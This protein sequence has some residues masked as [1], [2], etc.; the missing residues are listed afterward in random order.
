MPIRTLETWTH[1]A[2]MLDAQHTR[3]ALWAPDAFYVS[4]ELVDG[5]SLPMLPQPDGWFVIK[6]RCPAGT[7]YRFSIDGE[8]NVPDPASR[9][10][11][12]GPD[13]ASMVVDP[14][15]YHWQ[16]SAWQGRPWHQAV[17]YELHVGLLGGFGAVR[18]HLPRLVELGITAI[19]LMPLA[20]FPGERNWGYDGV[21]PYAPQSSYG[22]PDELKQLIDAA[23]GLGLAVILDVVYNHFG[24]DGSY[25]HQYAS[26][27]FR[28]DHQTPWGAAIDFRRR[29]VRD[30]FIDNALMWLLE[31]RFDGLRLDAVHAIQDQDFLQDLAKRVRQQV[32]PGRHVW[33]TVEN[34]HNQA[35][36]LQQGYDGQWNDDGHNALHVLLTG[37]TEAYYADFS[38]QPCALLA[39]CLSQ[40]FVY[41][42]HPDRH[43]KAR[44]EPSGHLPPTAF[45]LFLQNHDQIGNRAFGERLQ[46]LCP[47]AALHAATVLLLLSPMIP[48]MFMGDEVAASE[49]FLFFTSH[50][51]ELA[52]AVREGRRNEFASFKAFADTHVRQRIPD[53]NARVTFEASRPQWRD[54]EN[55]THAL[56][57]QLLQVRQRELSERLPGTRALGATVLGP[58]ALSARWQLGDG[59]VLCIELNLGPGAVAHKPQAGSRLLVEYPQHA[60]TQLHQGRL[61]AYSAIV[62]LTPAKSSQPLPESAN[63]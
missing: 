24:P 29:E 35:S 19:E 8:H 20:Q 2:V 50:Q 60:C 34:E 41:Q 27:F 11:V 53:P 7:R 62:S 23:H 47:P 44:G 25:Q 17:I 32:D 63:E 1:G 22:S 37:E 14:L 48:L 49:P 31:Y 15:T 54:E 26:P 39:R 3:F 30:F 51:G 46:K 4:L 43:G 10:Q 9:A 38:Q 55:P 21:L 28:Q 56:Y 57:R 58:Q 40:G 52:Q 59:S 36:L 5:Q 13:S 42:G 16:H 33:L 61:T 45:I 18:G 12:E 6:A